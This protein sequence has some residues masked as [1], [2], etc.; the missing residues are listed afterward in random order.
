MVASE[1]KKLASQTAK[2]TDE[3]SGQIDAIQ[4]ATSDAVTVIEGVGKHIV[5]VDEIQTA[6]ASAVEEKGAAATEISRN[7]QQAA[8]GTQEVSSNICDVEKAANESGAAAQ[9]VLDAAALLAN[10]SN[11]LRGEVDSFLI[12]AW[13]V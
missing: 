9:Q 13:A 4:G 11:S 8:A 5:D 7:A 6:I 10:Q 3:I 2:A 1:V 12:Q